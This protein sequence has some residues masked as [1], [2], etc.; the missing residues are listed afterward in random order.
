MKILMYMI[1]IKV[2]AISYSNIVSH[3]DTVQIADT[4]PGCRGTWARLT[5]DLVDTHS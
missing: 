1:A 2:V 5:L 4:I 3:V